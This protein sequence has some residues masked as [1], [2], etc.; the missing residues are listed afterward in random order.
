MIRLIVNFQ[1]VPQGGSQK[2]C[3]PEI[4]PKLSK[5][6]LLG[7]LRLLVHLSNNLNNEFQKL[8]Q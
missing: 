5:I 3:A 7:L 1:L 8:L 2:R 4:Q 6:N